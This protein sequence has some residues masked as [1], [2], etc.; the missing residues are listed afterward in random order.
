[1]LGR[2]GTRRSEVAGFWQR[3]G[4][5]ASVRQASELMGYPRQWGCRLVL[6]A[7]VA[8][9]W[10]AAACGGVESLSELR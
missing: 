1:M 4:Q 8:G 7:G 6:Q 9:G 10:G 2:P 3:L 5:G